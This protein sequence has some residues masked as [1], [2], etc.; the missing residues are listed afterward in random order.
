VAKRHEKGEKHENQKY[1]GRK[2]APTQASGNPKRKLYADYASQAV[3]R[4]ASKNQ[5]S[6]QNTTNGAKAAD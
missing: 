4:C 5:V 6:K 2:N 1:G 3:V